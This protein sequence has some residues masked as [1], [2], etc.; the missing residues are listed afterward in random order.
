MRIEQF[1]V[2]DLQSNC[3]LLSHNSEA[4]IIDPGDGIVEVLETLQRQGLTLV[5]MFATHGH[6]DHIMGAG[7]IQASFPV[8]L[9]IEES[10]MFLVNRM[11]KTARH[12][13]GYTPAILPIHVTHSLPT[14]HNF[15]YKKI[16]TPGHT[17]G[18]MTY[19][20]PTD[21][22]IFSGDTLFS[23]GVGST[24][25][26]YSNAAELRS[27]VNKIFQINGKPVCYPGH[28]ESFYVSSP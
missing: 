22:C 16:V 3:Y 24:E 28:G 20:F 25:H 1:I 21:N 17:P 15:T 10:D 12:F 23:T 11:E 5:G 9:Y 8:P 14:F 27:S 26:A 19:Y 4:I 18:S 2:G 7:E 6:F 13:L